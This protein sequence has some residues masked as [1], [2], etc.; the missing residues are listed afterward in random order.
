[1][2][3]NLDQV[4]IIVSSPLSFPASPIWASLI[5][6]IQLEKQ[7]QAKGKKKK[8]STHR[9][10]ETQTRK[11]KDRDKRHFCLQSCTRNKK[12][13]CFS[14][15][16]QRFSKKLGQITYPF[17]HKFLIYKK[18]K[19]SFSLFELRTNATYSG[20]GS[21]FLLYICI[22][23]M[24]SPQHYKGPTQILVQISELFCYFKTQ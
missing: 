15:V 14:Q 21:Y 10:S 4:T 6:D 16:Y 7:K 9:K 5:Q 23:C 8:K 1:M 3:P 13:S 2:H 24:H 18:H 11:C 17:E 12:N 20:K 19:N 22:I